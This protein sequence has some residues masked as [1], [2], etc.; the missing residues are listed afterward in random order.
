[1]IYLDPEFG[2]NEV[3]DEFAGAVEMLRPVACDPLLARH[4]AVLFAC[5]TAARAHCT[6]ASGG[7]ANTCPEQKD[8]VLKRCWSIPERQG[9]TSMVAADPTWRKL[10]V[11]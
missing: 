3:A 8:R 9:E 7:W 4:F 10:N 5:L 6:A 11:A 1:M 2:R